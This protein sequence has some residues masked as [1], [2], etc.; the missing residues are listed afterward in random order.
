MQ[1]RRIPIVNHGTQPAPMVG[2]LPV[3]SEPGD[4][5]GPLLGYT[6]D[7]P[8]VFFLL[9]NARDADAH[10]GARSVHHVVSPP[11]KFTEEADGTLTV[12]ESIGAFPHWH[13]FLTAGVWKEG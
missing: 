10:G 5:C 4:Y 13:G 2:D 3:L 1:G 12:R 9:P 7:K 11:H 6:G 8:A